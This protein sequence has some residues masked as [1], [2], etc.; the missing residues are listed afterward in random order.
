MLEGVLKTYET[1]D[2]RPLR[3]LFKVPM[4]RASG[5]PVSVGEGRERGLGGREPVVY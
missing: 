2:G 3:E 4:S 5:N 1:I